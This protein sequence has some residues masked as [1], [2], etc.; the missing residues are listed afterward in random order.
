MSQGLPRASARMRPRDVDNVWQLRANMRALGV[1]I[2]DTDTAAI[3]FALELACY[4]ADPSVDYGCLIGAAAEASGLMR[5]G[6]RATIT[7]EV[8]QDTVT[9]EV[10]HGESA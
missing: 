5:E 2:P 7:Y 8:E 3:R 1:P 4:V 9:Y 6:T 10:D